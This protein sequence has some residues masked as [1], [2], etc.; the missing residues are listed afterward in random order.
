MWQV[1]RLCGWTRIQT[2]TLRETLRLSLPV[3][4]APPSLPPALS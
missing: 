3:H 1:S 4:A 2:W